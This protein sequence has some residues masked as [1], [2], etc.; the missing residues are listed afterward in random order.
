MARG[1]RQTSGP[2]RP[3]P[4]CGRPVRWGS[5]SP[6]GHRCPHG[7]QCVAEGQTCGRC[8]A[9]GPTPPN[10]KDRCAAPQCGHLYAAHDETGSCKI[11]PCILFVPVGSRPSSRLAVALE[12]AKK[13]KC[14]SCGESPAPV[15]RIVDLCEP[16][17][18]LDRAA[19][20]SPDRNPR[21]AS[22]SQDRFARP[23]PPITDLIRRVEAEQIKFPSEFNRNLIAWL[24][25]LED[26][27][28]EPPPPDRPE[29]TR[30]S[31]HLHTRSVIRDALTLIESN[32]SGSRETIG[33]VCT[34]VRNV[35]TFDA[36]TLN[37]LSV[38]LCSAWAPRLN[39]GSLSQ[40]SGAYLAERAADALVHYWRSTHP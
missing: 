30:L 25:G 23:L 21:G 19:G 27:L 26:G 4:R 5:R 37:E 18:R 2:P 8:A 31:S 12:A 33:L 7:E 11:C 10:A 16:C 13:A 6:R 1:P 3:C 36:R 22:H 29:P 14:F 24:R 28:T 34:L 39:G 9:T 40:N 20:T 17:S 38:V 35:D 32:L 15:A